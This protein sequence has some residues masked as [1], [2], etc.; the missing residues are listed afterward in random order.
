MKNVCLLSVLFIGIV[1]SAAFAQDSTSVTWKLTKPDTTE[2]SSTVGPIVGYKETFAN[3]YVTI[4]NGPVG[5]IDSSQKV[6]MT[7]W[8]YATKYDT[9]T[10]IQF[11]VSP[12]PGNNLHITNVTIPCG[13][14]GGSNQ[15]IEIFYSIGMALLHL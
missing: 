3:L 7:T 11:A 14:H 2:V 12:A 15:T 9:G 6:C 4:Y 5:P 10:Y 1:F 8:P 13:A